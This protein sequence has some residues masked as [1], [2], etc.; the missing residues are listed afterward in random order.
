MR[1]GGDQ[2]LVTKA[3][4]RWHWLHSVSLR[5]STASLLHWSSYLPY[6]LPARGSR[7]ITPVL[8]FGGNEEKG[9]V[10]GTTPPKVTLD[11]TAWMLAGNGTELPS[12]PDKTRCCALDVQAQRLS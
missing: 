1:V 3:C 12:P 8:H 4:L 5:W 6:H 11:I 2:G 10:E 9:L 7:L